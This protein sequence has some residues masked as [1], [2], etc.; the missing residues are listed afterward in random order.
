MIQVARELAA[1]LVATG[2]IGAMVAGALIGLA[3]VVILYA[4][5]ASLLADRR[6]VA[7]QAEFQGRLLQSLDALR[8]DNLRQREEIERLTALVELLREQQRRSID[9]LRRVMDGRLAPAD[10][11]AADLPEAS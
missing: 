6:M 5:V 10:L 9:L 11:T 4:Q 7:Q 8:A 1:L 3:L 2:P